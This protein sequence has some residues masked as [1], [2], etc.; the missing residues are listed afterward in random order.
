MNRS[1]A[2]ISSRAPRLISTL[3]PLESV[4]RLLELLDLRE[5]AVD[6][7]PW[8]ESVLLEPREREL[9]WVKELLRE[10]NVEKRGNCL[11]WESFIRGLCVSGTLRNGNDDDDDDDV[12]DDDY[13][14][15]D[16]DDD[17]DDDDGDD[18]ALRKLPRA[19]V[20]DSIFAPLGKRPGVK[21]CPRLCCSL[22]NRV[23]QTKNTDATRFQLV[24]RCNS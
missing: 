17:D 1:K 15:D 20:Q 18:V 12:D 24:D 21:D 2:A 19:H 16:D 13:N 6:W 22:Y 11:F 23:N 5:L 10:A 4:L 9:A 14:G 7:L 8:E 3:V